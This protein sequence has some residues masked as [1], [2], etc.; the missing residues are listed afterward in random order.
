M[1]AAAV[2][3]LVV[4]P[5]G[6]I[7]RVV[8]DRPERRNALTRQMVA[9]LAKIVRD[10]ADDDETRVVVLRGSGSDFCS[11]IDLTES[12]EQGPGRPR[13]GHVERNE[14]HFVRHGIAE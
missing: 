14:P 5:D 12:N 2:P 4:L 13:T 11:G 7:L 8:L 1:S 10:A 3:G 9:E 6:P